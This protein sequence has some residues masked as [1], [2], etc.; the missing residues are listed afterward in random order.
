METMHFQIAQTSFFRTTLFR[1]QWVF[2]NNF[3]PM[4]NYPDCARYAKV[5]P[6]TL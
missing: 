6:G 2:I 5:A 4:N 3:G 1:M